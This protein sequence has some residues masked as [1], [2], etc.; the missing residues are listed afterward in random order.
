MVY[1][2]KFVLWSGGAQYLK[3]YPMASWDV[4]QYLAFALDMLSS[5]G[6]EMVV[7]FFVLSGFFIRHAQSTRQRT[8]LRFYVNRVVRIYPPYLFSIL[9][10]ALLLYTS[11][12][13][14]P[15]IA[16]HTNGRELNAGLWQAW[17]ELKNIRVYG[18]FCTIGFMKLDSSYL[19][20]NPVYWSLL[21]EAIFY[22]IVPLV[23]KNIKYYYIA[24]VFI[25]LLGVFWPAAW[26]LNPF[27]IY[28]LSFNVYFAAGVAFYDLVAHTPWIKW[29][30]RLPTA[31]H[32]A[33]IILLFAGL[34]GLALLKMKAVS[35]LLA[36]FLAIVSM[37]YLLSGKVSD[38]SV[39]IKLFGEI[40]KFSFSLYLYHFSLLIVAYSLIVF[41]TG[42]LVIY[43]HY[44][45]LVLPVVVLISYGLY[46]VSEKVFI[47]RTRII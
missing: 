36:M 6:Y 37:S 17:Q 33:V 20:Y 43:E 39:V 10:S 34:I 38:K 13:L 1:H 41:F 12:N 7:F 40:G 23:F 35:G 11:I 28:V 45:W 27:T 29:S 5:A 16:N 47:A 19:G 8:A 21:P 18:L 32:C 31:M 22:L 42:K 4:M 30:A 44:Y 2:A 46:Q 9:L 25:L 14:V 26:P 24:S 15:A 3:A